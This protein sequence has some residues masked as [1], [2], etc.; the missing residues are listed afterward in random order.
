MER[1]VSDESY[2]SSP[3]AALAPAGGTAASGPS[4]VNQYTTPEDGLWEAAYPDHSLFN[5]WPVYI[6][7]QYKTWT[8]VDC[9]HGA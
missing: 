3:S 2:H 5:G 6:R 4:T 7:W 9:G 1:S 8:V